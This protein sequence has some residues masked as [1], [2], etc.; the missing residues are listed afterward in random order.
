M[1]R[2][3]STR[4][5]TVHSATSAPAHSSQP[6]RASITSRATGSMTLPTIGGSAES[7]ALMVAARSLSS[8]NSENTAAPRM[9]KG[10]IDSIAR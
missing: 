1:S 5:P 2:I 9:K 3:V 4:L 6:L 7:T 10:K 8:P